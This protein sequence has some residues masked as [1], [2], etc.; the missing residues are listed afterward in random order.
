MLSLK[1]RVA[2]A[3]GWSEDDVNGFS[4]STIRELVR[5]KHSALAD[6][7]SRLIASGE[8]IYDPIATPCHDV[9]GEG[10]DVK[11]DS[12]MGYGEY[13]RIVF[14]ER[15]A[16]DIVREFNL[17]LAGLDEWIGHAEVEGWCV[18]STADMRARFQNPGSDLPDEWERWHAL[19][20]SDIAGAIKKGADK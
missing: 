14:G 9:A 18:H 5:P 10:R 12:P 2:V 17:V 20:L 4:F 7:I 11:A 16:E 6:E 3:L 19:A 15:S 1:A 13:W 8:H